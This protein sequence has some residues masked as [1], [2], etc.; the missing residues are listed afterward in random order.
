MEG[1][2]LDK[3]GGV[4]IATGVEVR[5]K[6]VFSIAE[7]CTTIP[8]REEKEWKDIVNSYRKEHETILVRILE[9][10]V[11]DLE[12]KTL[13]QMLVSKFR[14]ESRSEV[15][16]ILRGPR[17]SLTRQELHAYKKI[18]ATLWG[19]PLRLLV[20]FF[21]ICHWMGL[22]DAGGLGFADV[23]RDMYRK[24][25]QKTLAT[26]DKR[27]V[28][29]LGPRHYEEAS[30]RL[31]G[32][33]A[34][35]LPL[36]TDV[37]ES[38]FFVPSDQ[39]VGDEIDA[40][41]PDKNLRLSVLKLK[42]TLMEELREL[43]LGYANNVPFIPEKVFRPNSN[44]N[45]FYRISS[46]KNDNK[47]TLFSMS[48]GNVNLQSTDTHKNED[49][50][51][52]KW[53]KYVL[54]PYNDLLDEIRERVQQENP[55]SLVKFVP[56]RINLIQ[57]VIERGGKTYAMHDD[58]GY[59]NHCPVQ[60]RDAEDSGLPTFA[61][62]MPTPFEVVIPTLV[63][64][65]KDDETDPS[66]DPQAGHC[67]LTHHL[68]HRFQSD[69]GEKERIKSAPLDNADSK[70]R[71]DNCCAHFQLNCQKHSE[72]MVTTISRLMVGI[73]RAIL[74][75]RF[76][77]D[78]AR[79]HEEETLRCFNTYNRSAISVM[80]DYVSADC[81]THVNVLTSP[82]VRSKGTADFDVV[83]AGS[84]AGPGQEGADGDVTG[85]QPKKKARTI[86]LSTRRVI[87][88]VNDLVKAPPRWQR[89]LDLPGPCKV[90]AAQGTSYNIVRGVRAVKKFFARAMYVEHRRAVV[91]SDFKMTDRKFAQLTEQLLEGV[92]RER[93][94]EVDG[95]TPKTTGI[96][97]LHHNYIHGQ[98][99]DAETIHEN[100][101]IEESQHITD[102]CN[103]KHDLPGAV[104]LKDEKKNG[105]YYI[106]KVFQEMFP[107]GVT[108]GTD[109]KAINRFASYEMSE[110]FRIPIGPRG[111]NGTLQSA[112]GCGK[113][114]AS[115]SA[116][117]EKA[118]GTVDLDGYPQFKHGTRFRSVFALFAP[119]RW[120]DRSYDTPYGKNKVIFFG[121]YFWHQYHYTTHFEDCGDFQG[122]PRKRY[123]ERMYNKDDK[124]TI[125]ARPG[126]DNPFVV[127]Q[128]VYDRRNPPP[129][130]IR[131][132]TPR[133][134]KISITG[135]ERVS[136]S[137]PDMAELDQ[138][139]YE[140]I[141]ESWLDSVLEDN[142]SNVDGVDVVVPKEPVRYCSLTCD[143]F[144]EQLGRIG[145]SNFAR[146]DRRHNVR[147]GSVGY[148]FDKKFGR[149][150]EVLRSRYIESPNRCM[151]MVTLTMLLGKL[152]HTDSGFHRVSY[153]HDSQADRDY[154]MEALF[155]A[156]VLRC[157]T[158]AGYYVLFNRWMNLDNVTTGTMSEAGL[159][160][161]CQPITET[162]KVRLP[163]MSESDAFVNFLAFCSEDGLTGSMAMF[164]KVLHDAALLDATNST[165]ENFGTFLRG[166]KK[167]LN[168]FF[169]NSTLPTSRDV[170]IRSLESMF[171]ELCG[172]EKGKP[173]FIA[174]LVVL[175]VEEVIVDPFGSPDKVWLGHGGKRGI[176]LLAN[177]V[178]GVL[179]TTPVSHDGVDIRK[180]SK[181]A[182]DEYRHWK[183]CTMLLEALGRADEE[184]L[185]AI[186]FERRGVD[187]V[188]HNMVNN[189]PVDIRHM[190]HLICKMSYTESMTTG[191]RLVSVFPALSQPYGWPV[192]DGLARVYNNIPFLTAISARVT[193]ILDG[194]GNQ[195]EHLFGVI[196]FCFTFEGEAERKERLNDAINEILGRAVQLPPGGVNAELNTASVSHVV[197]Q[198]TADEMELDSDDSEES[199]GTGELCYEEGEDD[200]VYDYGDDNDGDDGDSED[201]GDIDRDT[202]GCDDGERSL[203]SA[204]GTDGSTSSC[205]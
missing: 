181:T 105:L 165:V 87:T 178:D 153:D 155:Q 149:L 46:N 126:A 109:C 187:G 70:V 82:V 160:Y 97:F 86:P 3:F 7:L 116:V 132:H 59:E 159:S 118:D 17:G 25:I 37:A 8:L 50:I 120:F 95:V 23:N 154:L 80:K 91:Q 134:S 19:E 4:S 122:T 177:A 10:D 69:G 58:L 202:D 30:K 145:L 36:G 119:V 164:T 26:F 93:Y 81:H 42:G 67:W 144:V 2:P 163:K 151:N 156:T 170:W 71:T 138:Y 136:V 179:K 28:M 140:D 38:E 205:D 196:P 162:D 89:C 171:K 101:G 168:E 96:K 98:I 35:V 191:S 27:P 92:V 75:L 135:H 56:C 53:G 180:M 142:G 204:S 148:L 16:R 169:D 198:L 143:E 1:T 183:A 146:Y 203:S 128:P 22:S 51:M 100:E 15:C 193:A 76:V 184:I 201:S 161:M 12:V 47:H 186:G 147:H 78:H 90:K 55:D 197:T 63:F 32:R 44:K 199:T 190:D 172:S 112:Y 45:R 108:D 130:V 117:V 79:Y 110:N 194:C 60:R 33:L 66:T 129:D 123:H 167:M 102:I 127:V 77:I 64:V 13:Q 61:A 107:E 94:F 121:Y 113:A 29:W 200:Q 166:Y 85:V 65:G 131:N 43:F 104:V 174:S 20:G 173:Y 125:W 72:H 141:V 99:Y 31:P 195:G 192:N 111:G 57:T 21:H 34:Q 182:R 188:V 114:G 52:E 49:A 137:A 41:N 74:S 73:W 62:T 150:G 9:S 88:A 157:A 68:K 152:S 115:D 133:T 6:M 83:G 18:Q 11:Q 84:L 54:D 158:T 103:R 24:R 40:T 185:L 14:A 139:Q 176:G 39:L 106:N 189:S 175:D 5:G 48:D 124:A